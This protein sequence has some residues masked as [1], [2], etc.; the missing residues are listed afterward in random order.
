MRKF[1][2]IIWICNDC[3]WDWETVTVILDGEQP[4]EECPSCKSF[5]VRESVAAPSV[6]FHG[7]GFYETDYK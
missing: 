4:S 1:K 6:R 7:N 5:D 2:T 3:E